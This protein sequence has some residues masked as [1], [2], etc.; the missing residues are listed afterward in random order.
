MKTLSFYNETGGGFDPT[1][2]ERA[3]SAAESLSRQL[4]ALNAGAAVFALLAA[5][6]AALETAMGRALRQNQQYRQELGRLRGALQEAFAPIYSVVLPG[7]LAM[8]RILSGAVTLLGRFFGWLS[9]GKQQSTGLDKE[10]KSVQK[11]G[12]AAK[13]AKKELMGFDEVN[14]L[15]APTDAAGSTGSTGGTGS[16]LDWSGYKADLDALTVYLSG[17]LLAIGAILAFSGVNIPLGIALMALGAAGIAS[18]VME[19]WGAL[20]GEVKTALTRVAVVLGG[21]A[22]AIGGILAFS[23]ANIPLGIGLMAAG[24]AGLA[25]A[26][27]LNWDTVKDAMGGSVG[28]LTALVSGALIAL[29]AVLAFSGVNLPLGIALM[30]AGT[31]G[32]V[33]VGALNWNAI[34]DKLKEVWAGIRQWWSASVAPKLTLSYWQEKFSAI[35]DALGEKI[36]DGVNTGI[37]IM[38]RFIDWINNALNLSWGGLD[39]FGQTVIPAGSYQLLTIPRIPMLAKG[40]VIPPNAPFMAMLGDQKTGTNIETPEELLRQIV[41][42]ESGDDRLAA[43]LETLIDTVAGIRVG[44]DVIGRA[45]GRYQRSQSRMGG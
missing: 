13:D 44:D 18:V 24:A 31:A 2:L 25:A 43:L 11:L 32:L 33:T 29:G 21:A 42:E 1:A 30:A 38:N 26:A 22:L 37:S 19:N 6:A 39:A 9:G 10:T 28:T 20:D 4:A 15:N 17:A 45:A 36:R 34:S 8:M 3:G 35:S 14:R 40:A 7:V 16:G 27:A 41:R 12:K 23:G 5:G